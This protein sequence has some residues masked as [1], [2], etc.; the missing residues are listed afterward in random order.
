MI[1]NSALAE[2]FSTGSAAAFATVEETTFVNKPEEDY[3]QV[4]L[5]CLI[6]IG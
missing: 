2:L 1:E 5:L 4:P 3:G 6:L